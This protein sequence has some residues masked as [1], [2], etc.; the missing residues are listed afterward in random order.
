MAYYIVAIDN[1]N[2][3]PLFLYAIRDCNYKHLVGSRKGNME[4]SFLLDEKAFKFAREARFLDKQEA[5]LRLEDKQKNG[6][7]LAFLEYQYGSKEYIGLF[8]SVSRDE[9]MQQDGW[10]YDIESGIYYIV[11]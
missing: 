8:Q 11:K 7:R 9:A 4:H 10:T 1:M 6:R 3:L 5:F 2:D